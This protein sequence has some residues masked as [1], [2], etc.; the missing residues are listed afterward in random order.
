MRNTF[1]KLAITA[2]LAACGPN[3]EEPTIEIGEARNLI[4][5]KVI[6]N[7]EQ[8]SRF[9]RIRNLYAQLKQ[10]TVA[11]HAR[12]SAESP[13][14]RSFKTE[15]GKLVTVKIISNGRQLTIQS[16]YDVLFLDLRTQTPFEGDCVQR[17]DSRYCKTDD[18]SIDGTIARGLE[19]AFKLNTYS[20]EIFTAF[21]LSP[22]ACP[23]DRA[24][25]IMTELLNHI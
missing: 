13:D 7:V 22:K 2:F 24:Q 5:T 16:G 12:A 14:V 6:D 11:K 3:S 19:A 4:Y 1:E 21:G 25:K 20:E 10:R 15:A 9:S 17:N 18:T 8:V 23:E